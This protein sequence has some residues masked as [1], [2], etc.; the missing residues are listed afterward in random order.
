M[1]S[2]HQKKFEGFSETVKL[3][4][5][6]NKTYQKTKE[7]QQKKQVSIHS[8][9]PNKS[10]LEKIQKNQGYSQEIDE[11]TFNQLPMPIRSEPMGAV[12][13]RNTNM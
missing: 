1:S 7:N 4:L 11:D 6:N 8:Y 5:I 9:L 10:L 13:R 2:K 3:L 12:L